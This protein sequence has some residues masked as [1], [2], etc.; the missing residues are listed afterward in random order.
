M[1]EVT[2]QPQ[3]ASIGIK[4]TPILLPRPGVDL[5]KWAVI[6]CDQFTSQ[7]EVWKA[8]ESSIGDS[9]STLH[10]ILPECYL[11]TPD[12]EGRIPRINRMMREYLGNGILLETE[13][14][15]VLVDRETPHT[16]RRGMV[17]ALDLEQYDYRPGT[18]PLI[19]P[20]EQ[21][22]VER[23][24][25]RLKIRRNASI[26]FPHTLVLLNDAHTQVIDTLFSLFTQEAPT[27]EVE[28]LLGAG[29]V[30]GWFV[31]ETKVKNILNKLLLKSL[32]HS[33]F[34]YAVGDGNHSLAAA[35]TFWEELK[36]QLSLPQQTTHPARYTLVELVSLFDEGI[37]FHPIHRILHPLDPARFM[38]FLETYS[39][40]QVRECTAFKE[41]K[42][43]VEKDP[44]Q[45]G[46][47]HKG[48]YQTVQVLK[49]LYQT[50]TE[51]AQS[52]I[53]AFC[54][55]NPD[56]KVDYIHGDEPLCNLSSNQGTLG[57]YLPGLAKENLFPL[58]E[59]QGVLPRKAF[60]I[61][62]ALEKRFYL[63]GRKITPSE[64]I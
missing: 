8:M 44:F 49:S 40:I 27:Y 58:I 53:D 41:M 55:A 16:R 61:G 63:E 12:E 51:V 37:Q 54:S 6:A 15:L 4:F 3:Q 19:R 25:P 38:D 20:T 47:V 10:C 33:S 30:R 7:P 45:I 64:R 11:G 28:L 31:P 56:T 42:E 17:I 59:T 43:E 2:M 48:A 5:G 60:S 24:P 57:I 14:G 22:L 23:L 29:K 26:E 39:P 34:L 13:P 35:K 1:R 9:P 32:D 50:I 36:K 18:K 46:L 52:V 21:T 62:E